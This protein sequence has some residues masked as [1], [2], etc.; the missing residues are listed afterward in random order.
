M[1]KEEIKK[2]VILEK[3]L[4]SLDYLSNN[5]KSTLMYFG[6][7]LLFVLVYIVYNNK[8]NQKTLSYNNYSSANQNNYIDGNE[9][10]AIIGF[11]NIMNTFNKS[12][13]YNQAFIYLL[14][15]ALDKNDYIELDLLINDN[16]FSTNDNTIQSYYENMKS[17]YYFKIGDI[18][19]SIKYCNAAIKSSTIDDHKNK[20][21]INLIY[22]HLS[23]DDFDKSTK[24]LQDLEYE[25]LSYDLKNKYSDI[26][27]RIKYLS[28]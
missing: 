5:I 28:N 21:I 15:D 26:N 22:L 13:S 27:S 20:F 10:L 11:D 2:D 12:E 6:V 14:A 4:S 18:N 19:N 24:L 9:E 7:F 16:K 8:S 25:N 3:I 23:N 17:N 1:K